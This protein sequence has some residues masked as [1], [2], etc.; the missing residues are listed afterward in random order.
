MGVNAG[1]LDTSAYSALFSGHRRLADIAEELDRLFLSPVVLG[2]LRAGFLKGAHR[3]ANESRLESF[4]GKP[5]VA[6]MPL[7]EA[8][9]HRYAVIMDAL[10]REGTPVP[11]NDVWIAAS[12]MEHG[13]KV[14][15]L[16][17]HFLEIRQI[18]VECF[19]PV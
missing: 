13:L 15:T 10:R 2:E 7:V 3:A 5:G 12:A 17:K 9:A 14:L 19:E 16:D 11:T 4:L 6:V 8:T 1:L 18:L